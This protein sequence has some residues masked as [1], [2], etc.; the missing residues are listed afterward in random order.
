MRFREDKATALASFFLEKAGGELEY[1]KLLKLMYL[2]ERQSLRLL[3]SSVTGDTFYSMKHGPV[4]SATFDLIKD[5]EAWLDFDHDNWKRF[6]APAK[7][8]RIKLKT[9]FP[10]DEALSPAEISLADTIW[11]EFKD[12]D[13][14]GLVEWIHETFPEWQQT[15]S[16]VP[17]TVED[18]FRAFNFSE[19]Q[20][21]SR[22]TLQAQIDEFDRLL[23]ES[24]HVA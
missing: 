21:K 5:N 20:V 12:V 11:N 17:I 6:I 24:A 19:E 3:S 15:R 8:F 16:R 22:M 13:Q 4:M 1:L 18:L 10:L 14:W 23:E 7:N 2:V 9:A